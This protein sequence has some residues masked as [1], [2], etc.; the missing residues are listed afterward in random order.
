MQN[1]DTDEAQEI[2]KKLDQVSPYC[3]CESEDD[4][5]NQMVKFLEEEEVG[6]R[7]IF[8]WFVEVLEDDDIKYSGKI[9][10]TLRQQLIGEIQEKLREIERYGPVNK[11]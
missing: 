10:D 8:K 9:T 6:T 3:V 2:N 4:R 5:I 7:N 1:C 11:D